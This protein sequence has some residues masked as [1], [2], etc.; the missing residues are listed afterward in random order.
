MT[1]TN[2]SHTCGLLRNASFS[3]Q[4]ETALNKM[5]LF[6]GYGPNR[7]YIQA[8]SVRDALVVWYGSFR[9]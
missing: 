4:L 5:I 8:A 2:A 1:K 3:Y 7:K 6:L 9:V